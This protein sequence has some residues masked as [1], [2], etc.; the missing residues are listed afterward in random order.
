MSSLSIPKS[1][2]NPKNKTVHLSYYALLR[3]ERGIGDETIHTSA[4]TALDLYKELQVRHNFSL[5]EDSVKVSVND[6]FSSWQTELNDD[7]RIVFI[8]PVSGG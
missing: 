6:T 8:P 3:E 5:T 1:M 4:T 2:N 7:D